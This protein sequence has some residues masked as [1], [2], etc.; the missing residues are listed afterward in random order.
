M[1]LITFPTS[2]LYLYRYVA[3]LT[4]TTAYIARVARMTS[5]CQVA[6]VE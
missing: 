3:C 4:T 6:K 1:F 5:N 2:K